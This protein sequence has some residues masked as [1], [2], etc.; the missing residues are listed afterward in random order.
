MAAH[1]FSAP[2][3]N[4]G[5]ASKPRDA[6]LAGRPHLERR[7][8]LT[9]AQLRLVVAAIAA[10]HVAGGWAV[11]QVPAV[12]E[13]VL[14]AAPIFVNFVA[15]AEQPKP[16][17]V[18]PPPPPPTR[19]VTKAPPPPANVVTTASPAP[20]VFEAPP[21]VATPPTPEPA[22]PVAVEVPAPPPPPPPPPT[23]RTVPSEA[24][25][26]IKEP[27]LRYPE[28][29]QRLREAGTAVLKVVISEAGIV[30]EARLLKS[31]GYSRL[32]AEALRAAKLA[33][34]KPYTVNGRPEPV[35][36]DMPLVF[37]LSE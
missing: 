2:P 8:G 22:P 31:S 3:P 23:P 36:T 4:T 34:F 28:Q 25:R 6:M 37:D 26:Y 15:P 24:V 33:R 11:M 5:G 17:V 35:V 30:Q 19:K 27:P 1:S 18:P 29:S 7:D 9:K 21:P 12:R 14:E 20:A 16:E 32:D 13:A 10:L